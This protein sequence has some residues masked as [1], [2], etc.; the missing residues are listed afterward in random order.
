MGKIELFQLL[1][2]RGLAI[3]KNQRR[4]TIRSLTIAYVVLKIFQFFVMSPLNVRIC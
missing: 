3:T 4:K 1:C 2:E